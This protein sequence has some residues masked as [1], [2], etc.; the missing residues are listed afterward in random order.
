MSWTEPSV[1]LKTQKSLQF[2]SVKFQSIMSQVESINYRGLALF[3]QTLQCG[4]TGAGWGISSIFGSTENRAP[5]RESSGD[6]P[7]NNPVH[8]MEHSS[9]AIQLKDPPVVLK[10]SENQTELEAME[11]NHTKREL[12]NVFIRKLYRKSKAKEPQIMSKTKER[13]LKQ[14]QEKEKRL[15][16]SR[17]IEVLEYAAAFIS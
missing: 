2:S 5:P 1:N 6:K 7:Y 4:T 10:I 12:H 15:L 14:I 9:S 17:S 8:T 3:A 11:V 13:K 16:L